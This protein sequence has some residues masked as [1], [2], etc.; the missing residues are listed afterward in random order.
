LF[1]VHGRP[2]IFRDWSK[3]I[4]PLADPAKSG[5][6]PGDAFEVSV[7]SLPRFSFSTPLTRGKENSVSTADPF[8]TLMT[9]VPSY[10]KLAVDASDYGALIG[11]R[12]AT[13]TRAP[14]P[15][16]SPRGRLQNSTPPAL[17]AKEETSWSAKTQQRPRIG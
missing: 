9:G 13:S 10:E 5:G 3:V 16:P 8:H 14:L 17:S 11:A 4:P 15:P 7:P 1:P 12:P 6:D 2:R